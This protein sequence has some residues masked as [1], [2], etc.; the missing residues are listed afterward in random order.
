[1]GP[2]HLADAAHAQEREL[3]RHH[4]GSSGTRSL[5]AALCKM[6]EVSQASRDANVDPRPCRREAFSCC[7]NGMTSARLHIR[8]GA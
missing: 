1:M 8:L 3:R 5:T 6:A 2:P 4:E 7:K